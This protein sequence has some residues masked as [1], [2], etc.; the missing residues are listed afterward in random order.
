V[1]G[2]TNVDGRVNIDGRA[3]LNGVINANA[4]TDVAA[5]FGQALGIGWAQATGNAAIGNAALADA[6]TISTLQPNSPFA[7]VGVL[8][9]DRLVSIGGRRIN[10][11]DTFSQY[12]YGVQPG[13]RIPLVVYRNGAEQTLY[14]TPDA[15]F[16][17][18]LPPP[19]DRFVTASLVYV[20][21]DKL[22][23]QFDG[24][25]QEASIVVDVVE[26]SPAHQ[27]GVVRGDAIVMLNDVA[28]GG[29]A[30]FIAKLEQ[31]PAQSPVKLSLAREQARQVQAEV[32]TPSPVTV[33]R[34]ILPPD[35]AVIPPAPIGPRPGVLPGPRGPV[36]RAIRP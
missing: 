2:Q 20:P 6:L 12:L 26:G 18:A 5:R 23:L 22:G 35:G 17:E 7:S 9:G 1:N 10:S 31:L 13:Q 25:N 14:W 11:F 21:G 32:V 36:R 33:G 27:A 24:R 3:N 30:D 29:P 15:Q 34:P 19:Q 28:V 8:P 16:V 4:G